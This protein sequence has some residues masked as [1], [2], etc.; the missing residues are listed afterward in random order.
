ML[1]GLIIGIGMILPGVSGGVLAVILGIYDKL[2]YCLN[3]F[4]SDIKGNIKFLLPIIF[5]LI[6]GSVISA[7]ILKFVFETYYVEVCY[8][9]IGLILGSVP[10]LIKDCNNKDKKGINYY[11]LI[12]VFIISLI[13]T[14]LSKDNFNFS[15]S[16]D[17]SFM[18]VIKLLLTGVLFIAGKVIPGISSSFM[19]MMIGMYDYFLGIVSNPFEFLINNVFNMIVILIGALLGLVIFIKMMAFLLKKH[20]SITY[21]VIIGFVLGSLIMIYP[22]EFNFIGIILLLCGVFV[23]YYFSNIKSD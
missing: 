7:N 21:S 3:N 23:S 6:I 14:L 12:I 1:A 4:K 10:Y 20:Y 22:N 8:L 9:F 16:L 11:I 15:S 19:L 18:S 13:I 17:R 5:G 2:I